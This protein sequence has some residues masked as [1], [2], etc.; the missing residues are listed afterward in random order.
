MHVTV[1]KWGHSA[2]V[3]IPSAIMKAVNLSLDETVDVREEGGRIVIE[4]VRNAKEYDLEQ[5]LAGITPENCTPK[6][7]SVRQSAR[8]HFSGSTLRTASLA[9]LEDGN[10]PGFRAFTAWTDHYFD[11]TIERR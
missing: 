7:T 10:S 11:V 8:R 5:L 4:P 6:L 1:K 9:H 2:S 3:R